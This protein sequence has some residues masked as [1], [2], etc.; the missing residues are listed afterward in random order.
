MGVA[1]S[2]MSVFMMG[3][4]CFLDE[5]VIAP[6]RGPWLRVSQGCGATWYELTR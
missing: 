6:F 2:C 5:S 1:N 3:G 4:Y